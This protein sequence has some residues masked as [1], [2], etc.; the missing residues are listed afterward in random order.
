MIEQ[1]GCAILWLMPDWIHEFILWWHKL[2]LVQVQYSDGGV[3][4]TWDSAEHGKLKDYNGTKF[5]YRLEVI[6]RCGC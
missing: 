3:A 1:I 6:E 4:Y 2:Y 5:V